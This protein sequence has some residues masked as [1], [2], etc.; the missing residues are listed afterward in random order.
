MGLDVGCRTQELVPD[1]PGCGHEDLAAIG[2]KQRHDP[3]AVPFHRGNSDPPQGPEPLDFVGNAGDRHH[4]DRLTGRKAR[5]PHSK[6]ADLGL[7]QGEVP[8]GRKPLC[9]LAG[10]DHVRVVL[11]IGP[12]EVPALVPSLGLTAVGFQVACVWRC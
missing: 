1:M 12:G 10:E 8:R 7:F 2:K 9:L 11:T 6:S 3:A 5:K 4:R